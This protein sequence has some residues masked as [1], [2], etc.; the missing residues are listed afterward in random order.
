LDPAMTQ[1]LAAFGAADFCGARG[2][3]DLWAD[4][5]YHVDAVD[6][7]VSDRILAEFNVRTRT[8]DSNPAGLILS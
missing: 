4:A 2:L 7:D 5:P 6:G 1:A 3:S 8:R